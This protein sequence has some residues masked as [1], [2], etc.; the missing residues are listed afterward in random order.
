MSEQRVMA[1]AQHLLQRE[2]Q[3]GRVAPIV[4]AVADED[5]RLSIAGAQE[6]TALLR[7]GRRWY[8]PRGATPTT[9]ILKLPMG[10]VGNMKLDLSHSIENEWLCSRVLAAY[11]LLVAECE[12]LQFEDMTSQLQSMF[13]NLGAGKPDRAEAAVRIATKFNVIFLGGV[14]VLNLEG[15]WTRY[16]DPAALLAP[17][18]AS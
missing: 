1:A 4:V 3:A 16:D 9:H 13:Q 18:A 15:L 2:L 17:A 14:G 6:K 5:L 8:R 11:G 10:L 7:M 12:P